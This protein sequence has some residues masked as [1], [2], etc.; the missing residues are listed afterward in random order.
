MRVN[1]AVIFFPAEQEHTG[2]GV[3]DGNIVV[4]L[5]QLFVSS[6]KGE[7]VVDLLVGF[8]GDWPVDQVELDG[9]H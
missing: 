6:L 4:N 2:P 5:D 7:E 9:T 3:D 8:E 1:L